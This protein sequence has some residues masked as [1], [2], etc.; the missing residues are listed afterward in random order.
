[1]AQEIYESEG[2]E[3]FWKGEDV[4]SGYDYKKKECY[5]YGYSDEE[6]TKTPEDEKEIMEK[7]NKLKNESLELY[8]KID[9][10]K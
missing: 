7:K 6:K 4:I 5:Y 10:Q 1:M 8:Y 9:S 3:E 2:A